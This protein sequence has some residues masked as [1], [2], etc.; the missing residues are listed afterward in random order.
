MADGLGDLGALKRVADTIRFLAADAVQKANSG[1]PGMPMGC[2]DLA[3]VLWARH[4]RFD[5]DHPAWMGRD[6]F[7][8]SAGHGSMLQYALLHLFGFDLSMDELVRFRQWG[9][10]TPGHPERGEAPGV[11]VTT[12]PLGQGIANAVGMALGAKMASAR[13]ADPGFDPFDLKVYALSG[14]GCMM[15]GVA[16]EA[17]SLA[18]HLRLDNLVVLYDSNRITIEGSTDLAFTED[19]AERYRAFGWDVRSCDGH[20]LAAVDAAIAAAKLAGKPAL[21]ICKTHIAFGAPKKQDTADAHGAPLGAEEIAA[22]KTALGF[23]PAKNFFIADDVAADCRRIADLKRAVAGT[24]RAQFT[25]WFDSDEKRAALYTD[26]EKRRLPANLLSDLFAAAPQKADATRSHGCAVLQAAAERVPFLVGGSADLEPSNKSFV[27]GSESIAAGKFGGRNLHFGVR[28]HAMGAVCNGLAAFGGWRP[29]AATFLV[30]ADYMRPAIRL[31]A[32]M[33]LPVVYVFT[34]D[35]F[36]VGEDGPTHQ[37]I[38]HVEALRMI[39]GL[40]VLRPADAVETAAAW[41]AALHHT[42]PTAI[43]LTRQKVPTIYRETAFGPPDLVMGAQALGSGLDE[44]ATMVATGSEVGLAIEAAKILAAEGT[45]LRVVSMMCRERFLERP[46]IERDRV[47]P[48]GQPVCSIEAGV[49]NGWVAITGRDGLRIGLDRFGASAP[50]EELAR[51][52]GF[53]AESVAARLREWLARV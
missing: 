14:D 8:L 7:V 22:A 43:I 27:K 18:G 50:A 39:P 12:G 36:Q 34:H 1:H 19:V 32:L 15:E 51:Q 30:F 17:A 23:D 24:W 5:P 37:P 11:E 45:K 38:E 42:G 2:A 21:V 26:F 29:Y 16:Y 35:S 28:E 4:L 41:F 6:R 49:T 10:K 9:S 44:A 48:P 52:F 46:E 3:T 33:H 31:A 53:V 25:A 20:D 47:V 40:R 13:F